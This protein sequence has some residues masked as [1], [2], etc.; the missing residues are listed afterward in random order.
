MRGDVGPYGAK[1]GPEKGGTAWV[2][3]DGVLGRDERRGAAG[4][5]GR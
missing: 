3:G 2:A 1:K 4:P 5:V